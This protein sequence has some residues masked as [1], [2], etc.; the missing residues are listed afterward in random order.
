MILKWKIKLEKFQLKAF[1][2]FSIKGISCYLITQSIKLMPPTHPSFCPRFASFIDVNTPLFLGF[3]S[4]GT[5]LEGPII[6]LISAHYGWSGM[7]YLMIGL[8][9]VGALAVL[10][11]LSIY[12]SRQGKIPLE[13]EEVA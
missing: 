9:G 5:F 8:S 12:N 7:F 11:A 4:V 2:Y 6:G 10:Q 3:G 1:S 13:M